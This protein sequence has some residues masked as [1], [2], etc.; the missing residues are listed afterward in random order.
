MKHQQRRLHTILFWGIRQCAI[1]VLCIAFVQFCSV[2]RL[3]V[4]LF[5]GIAFVQFSFAY[6]LR[7]ISLLNIAFTHLKIGV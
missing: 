7:A 6:R 5:C 2:Y 3:H 4:I 1:L